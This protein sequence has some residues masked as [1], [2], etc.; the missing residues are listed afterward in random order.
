MRKKKKINRALWWGWWG[1]WWPPGG[2][3]PGGS[4][5]DCCCWGLHPHGE[6][7]PTHASTVDPPTLAGTVWLL[8]SNPVWIGTQEN[9]TRYMKNHLFCMYPVMQIGKGSPRYSSSWSKT[10]QQVTAGPDLPMPNP[11]WLPGRCPVSHHVSIHP[12]IW[13]SPKRLLGLFPLSFRTWFLKMENTVDSLAFK[14]IN[15]IPIRIQVHL[16]L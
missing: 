7:L 1:W 12:Q 3:R 5:W 16:R 6:L 9:N 14:K 13:T 15:R 2:L 8:L 4:F 11:V 10:E